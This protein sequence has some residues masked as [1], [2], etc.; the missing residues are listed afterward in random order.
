MQAITRLRDSTGGTVHLFIGTGRS[1]WEITFMPFTNAYNHNTS[2]HGL[3]GHF[4]PKLYELQL[5]HCFW[6]DL[7]KVFLLTGSSATKHTPNKNFERGERKNQIVR[8]RST[9]MNTTIC[10]PRFD[11]NEPTPRWEGHKGRVF[12]NPFPLLIDQLNRLSASS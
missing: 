3:I 10:F 4:M 6:E 2:Y 7:P 1:L 8:W 12:F 5:R 9:Q 11:S